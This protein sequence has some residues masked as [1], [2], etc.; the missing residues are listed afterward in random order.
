[1]TRKEIL[2]IGNITRGRIRRHA[3]FTD[4]LEMSACMISSS[5]DPVHIQQRQASLETL[6]QKYH[7]K[8]KAELYQALLNLIKQ[9]CENV[10]RGRFE[11][12]LGPAFMELRMGSKGQDFTP[13]DICALTARLTAPGFQTLPDCGYFTL[14]EPACGACGMVLA[15]A[16]QIQNSGLNPTQH[17]VVRAEDLDIRCVW[18]S[19]IQ[20][21]LYGI[22]AVVIHGSTL[23]LEEI[24]RWYTPAY[25]LG[26]WVWRE[27]MPF[28][29]GKNRDNE[30]LKMAADPIYRAI[31]LMQGG[32][33]NGK[34][35][36]ANDGSA[37]SS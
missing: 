19:Y 2:E 24:D 27:P 33:R 18:M 8:E 4:F 29:Y 21:S 3:V 15:V 32:V 28:G 35:Y 16:E 10:E 6:L 9:I 5:F 31:R 7:P 1:M 17:L 34:V 25:L 13:R 14:D 22:P 12:L 26:N 36:R 30:L 23:S 37:D 11:D 20:L